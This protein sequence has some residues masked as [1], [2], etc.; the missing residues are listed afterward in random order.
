MTKLKEIPIEGTV[1]VIWVFNDDKGYRYQIY[2]NDEPEK[3]I[4]SISF[5]Y[6][7]AEDLNMKIDFKETCDESAQDFFSEYLEPEPGSFSVDI[8]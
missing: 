7:E 1:F 5:T 4:P 6:E 3:T 2:K 8:V